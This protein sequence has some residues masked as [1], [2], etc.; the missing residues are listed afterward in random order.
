MRSEATHGH[1]SQA[2]SGRFAEILDQMAALMSFDIGILFNAVPEDLV[3][4]VQ[5]RWAALGFPARLVL[6]DAGEDSP[7]LAETPIADEDSSAPGLWRG[8]DAMRID[9][10]AA[11]KEHDDA[12]LVELYGQFSRAARIGVP[13]AAGMEAFIVAATV[14][15]ALD[16]VV[17]DPQLVM[18]DLIELKRFRDDPLQ[19]SFEERGYFMAD[20]VCSAAEGFWKNE[21]TR[22]QKTLARFPPKT[23]SPGWLGKLKAQLGLAPKPA[24]AGKLTIKL[25][26]LRKRRGIQASGPQ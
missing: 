18:A 12:D 17:W 11:G 26:P 22:Y 15:E 14:A 5:R 16:G 3:A 23:E 4:R 25:T 10:C 9:I 19:M 2:R 21:R 1:Q 13:G 20:V 7:W 8:E 6:P 24:P